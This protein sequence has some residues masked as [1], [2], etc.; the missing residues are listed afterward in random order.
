MTKFE[1]LIHLVHSMTRSEKKNFRIKSSKRKTIPDYVYLY[2]TIEAEPNQNP[3]ALRTLFLQKRPGAAFES[4]VNYLFELILETALEMREEQDKHYMLFNKIMK[5]RVLYEKSLFGETFELLENVKLLSEKH[6]NYHALLLAGRLELEYLL[7]LNFPNLSEAELLRKQ[8]KL[9]E[10]LKFLRKVNEQSSLYEILKHR[11]LNKGYTRS[12]EQKNDLNDL[13][14]SEISI[15]AS[16]SPENFEISKLHQLFQSNYLI[17]VGDYKSAL[18][19]FYEL[20]K[21]FEDNKH[22]WNTPPVYYIYTIEGV[23]ESLR[24]IRNY[25]GMTYFINQ[26]KKIDNTSIDF[27]INITCIIFLF[28]LFPHLDRGDFKASEELM[29]DY[30]DSLFNKLFSLNRAQQA[31]LCLYTSLIHFGNEEYQKAHKFLSQ[32]IIRGKS[33][34]YLPLYRT[35]R[36][37]NLMIIYKLKDFDLIKY[38]IRSIKRELSKSEKGYKIERFLLGFLQKEIPAM[39]GKRNLLWAKHHDELTEIQN[40]VF[41]QPVLRIFDFTVWIESVLKQKSLSKLLRDKIDL[42]NFQ[43]EEIREKG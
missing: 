40:D 20:N 29:K 2:D 24:S 31:E 34:F 23:L 16:L 4:T 39:P 35:I 43:I 18:R 12:L 30:K 9:N 15:V 11:L 10:S 25:S 21:L 28:E 5:A 22:L 27:K 14:Y 1:S 8:F 33:Y 6:E 37:V 26:L 32:I 7:A 19:S 3:S 38:E 13:V 41:E 42:H 36:M 17:S